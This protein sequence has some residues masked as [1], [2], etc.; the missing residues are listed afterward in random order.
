MSLD[1]AQVNVM[2]RRRRGVGQDLA[3]GAART[4][5]DRINVETYLNGR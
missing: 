1:L 3:I 4:F 2:E 5:I